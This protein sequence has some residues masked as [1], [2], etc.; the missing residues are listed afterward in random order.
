MCD[1]A[2][3]CSP[4]SSICLCGLL[5]RGS[6]GG[7]LAC[8]CRASGLRYLQEQTSCA[9]VTLLFKTPAVLVPP[10]LL[11]SDKMRQTA[12]GSVL[13]AA[14]SEVSGKTGSPAA[15]TRQDVLGLGVSVGN[16]CSPGL[17][18]R[19]RRCVR[20]SAEPV[21]SLSSVRSPCTA[22]PFVPECFS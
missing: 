6:G 12:C 2:V 21:R 7:R 8:I 22:L 14:H 10:P 17:D 15:G 1:G 13:R 9:A 18:M 11:L 16:V 4:A 19:Q 5:M 20:L 3:S